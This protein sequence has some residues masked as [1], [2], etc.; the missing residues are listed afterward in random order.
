[1]I[2]LGLKVLSKVAGKIVIF[3]PRLAKL[4]AVKAEV[5]MLRFYSVVCTVN[6]GM[7]LGKGLKFKCS[8]TWVTP[9]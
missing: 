5:E 1:M 7:N 8:N 4:L 3:S 6:Q 2:Y 9:N